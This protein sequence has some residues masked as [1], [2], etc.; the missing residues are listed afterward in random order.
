MNLKFE[1]K[2]V[3][4]VVHSNL[5]PLLHSPGSA[6]VPAAAL[7]TARTGAGAATASGKQDMGRHLDCICPGAGSLQTAS[8]SQEAAGLE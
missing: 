3:S 1:E 5:D 8:G 4:G 7:P 6:P 2:K